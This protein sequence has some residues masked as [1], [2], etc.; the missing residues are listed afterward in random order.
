MTFAYMFFLKSLHLY[1]KPLH[2]LHHK[3]LPCMIILMYLILAIKYFN[4]P[5]FYIF[6]PLDY[7]MLF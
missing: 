6:I 4:I 5:P 3:L 1:F 7:S 2:K